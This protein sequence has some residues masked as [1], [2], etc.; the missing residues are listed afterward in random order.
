MHID[1]PSKLKTWLKKDEKLMALDV[2]KRKIGLAISDTGLAIASPL[3]VIERKK[4]K[5]D[6][7]QL[8]THIT[9]NHAGGFIIGYPYNIDGSEGARCQSIRDFAQKMQEFIQLPF[10]F[11]DERLS[12]FLAE[13]ALSQTGLTYKKKQKH[14]DKLAACYI[15]QSALDTID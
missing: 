12:T 2:S 10:C 7:E 9:V 4:F 15:L 1:Q 6:M 14:I 5:L 13:D 11:Y 3:A 8:Q